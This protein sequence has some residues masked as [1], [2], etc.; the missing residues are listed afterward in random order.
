MALVRTGAGRFAPPSA[1][2][3][4]RENG[5]L[6]RGVAVTTDIAANGSERAGPRPARGG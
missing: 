3:S 2:P 5:V 6:S 4:A 1:A